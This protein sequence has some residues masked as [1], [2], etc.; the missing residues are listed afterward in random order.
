MRFLISIIYVLLFH[1]FVLANN[2]I[3]QDYVEKYLKIAKIESERTGI[4]VS[5]KLGQAILESNMGRS[6]LAIKANNHFGIK[7]GAQ[8]N[9]RTYYKKDDDK[10]QHGDLINSCFKRFDSAEASFRAHS[11]FL[12]DPAKEHRYGFLFDL[13]RQDYK[14]WS[15]GLSEAG[16]ATDPSY[17]QK[18]IKVI[19]KYELNKY[20]LRT[21]SVKTEKELSYDA[22][23]REE[24][25]S[26]DYKINS[27]N[28]LPYIETKGGESYEYLSKQAGISIDDILRYNEALDNRTTK[29]DK[30]VKIFL[31]PKA[32]K[33]RG[34]ISY[35]KVREG[36]SLYTI[37]QLYGVKL[38]SLRYKN[39][40]PKDAEPLVGER[41]YLK[42]A[43]KKSERPRYKIL[44]VLV[45][46]EA[47]LWE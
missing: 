7:C 43:P 45:E 34:N 14:S 46:E 44:N 42:K 31:K 33:Y 2:P 23:R 28:R 41:I 10:N 30:G 29:L 1:N 37:A 21:Y 36:E 24:Q 11:D 47:Y 17:P 18:L 27:E 5:I 40:I 38:S 12:K 15:Q 25:I 9:G 6:D 32:R 35:H 8:W 16:Y 26:E 13:G 39:K 4:P 20:D 22:P 19:E 3:V